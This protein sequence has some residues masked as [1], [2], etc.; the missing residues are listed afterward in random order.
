MKEKVKDIFGN[1]NET[2]IWTCLQG[3]M[4]EIHT[5]ASEDAAMA[6]LGDFAFYARKPN[7]ELVNFKEIFKDE[8]K[9]ENIVIE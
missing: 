9:A 4:G 7:K 2:I 3:V 5:S 8:L 6:I 1:W